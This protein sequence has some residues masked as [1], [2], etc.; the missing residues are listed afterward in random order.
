[1]RQDAADEILVAEHDP[2]VAELIRRYL[3][4]DGL[5]VR[6]AS[7]PE[8]T[9]AALGSLAGVAAVVLDLTMPGLDARAIRRLIRPRPSQQ[10]GAQH[11]PAQQRGAQRRGSPLPTV[12]GPAPGAPVIC[13]TAG[14]TAQAAQALRPRHVGIGE[15]SCVTRPF[16]PRTLVTRV[17]A[18]I[19]AGRDP[20]PVPRAAGRLRLDPARRLARLDGTD[21]ALTGTEFDLLSCLVGCA[22]RAVS[23]DRLRRAVWGEDGGPGAR[24][25]DVYVAQLRAKMGPGNPI[26]TVRGT[27]YVLDTGDVPGDPGGPPG[28]PREPFRPGGQTGGRGPAATIGDAGHPMRGDNGTA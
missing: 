28:E 14:E 6:C 15:E 16:G 26:R 7:T 5:R 3:A 9:E 18:A 13:L 1:M 2:A 23:R 17:R 10:R 20:G 4:R 8:Q 25:V 11:W 19:R 22:G 24:S 12:A 27:G 21:I